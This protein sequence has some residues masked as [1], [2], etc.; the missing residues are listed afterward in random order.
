M[1]AAHYAKVTVAKADS[2]LSEIGLGVRAVLEGSIIEV[3]S[4][5][6][7]SGEATLPASFR[8]R[9]A[10]LKESGAT[11]LVVYRD[12]KPIGILSVTDTVRETA[13]QTIE[14]LRSLGVTR[15]GILSGDH[16]KAVARIASATGIEETWA[17]L[18]PEDKLRVID[19]FHRKGHRVMFV[20][21]G[22]NDAPALARADI[23]VAMG[24]AGTD[25]ALETAG[26]ALTRDEVARLP[27]L[28]RLSRRMLTLIKVNIALGLVFNV[29]AILGSS[30]GLLSP[31]AAALFHNAGSIIVV[32]SSASLFLF[33]D[34][35]AGGE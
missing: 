26:I 4:A 15:M 25:V 27:F 3:G 31:I 33:Q 9:L 21:D 11:P 24:A 8:E 28:V 14:N 20:G 18:K 12:Q 29:V 1:K 19:E 35:G 13:Q 5:Y 22:V 10:A 16:E 34:S 6:L 23:G 30:Y 17:G 32:V 2:V 7:G